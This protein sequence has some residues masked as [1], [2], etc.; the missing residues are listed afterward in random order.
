MTDLALHSATRPFFTFRL[1]E[2]RLYGIDLEHVREIAMPLPLTPVAHAPPAV[3]GLVNLRSRIHLLLDIR[4][5]LGFPAA[6][7]T[8]ESRLI[9]LRPAVAE[10]TGILVDRG[11]D[12]LRV[13]PGVTED[14][15]A[16]TSAD[17]PRFVTG[18]CKLEQD[19]LMVVAAPLLVDY[20]K[21]LLH[22]PGGMS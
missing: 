19:L 8:P 5:M 4:S 18:I 14:I 6:P 20:V 13:P 12:I 3:A 10:N 22:S 21:Q 16:A 7:T 17:T 2:G 9:I 1:G 15:P 11:G